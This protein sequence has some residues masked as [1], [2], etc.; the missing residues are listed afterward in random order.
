M[1]RKLWSADALVG[2]L[3]SFSGLTF[4]VS[5]DMPSVENIEPQNSSKVLLNKHFESFSVLDFSC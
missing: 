3:V 1:Q 2:G 4:F 5:G